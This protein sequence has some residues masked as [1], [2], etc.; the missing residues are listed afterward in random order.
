[1]NKLQKVLGIGSL[2][3][4]V[5][6]CGEPGDLAKEYVEKPVPVEELPLTEKDLTTTSTLEG[7]IIKV[8]PSSISFNNGSGDGR[9]ASNHE[10]EYVLVEN[11]EGLHTLIYPFSKAI[12]ER[13]ARLTFR[14]LNQRMID[15][16]TFVHRF[17]NTDYSTSDNFF[18]ESEGI[19]TRDGIHYKDSIQKTSKQP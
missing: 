3:S 12:L 11:S 5:Y 16:E 14:P 10:I 2:F 17:L 9:T 19:I 6:G 8:Q 7:R 18:L 13:D 15:V 1:M 4:V